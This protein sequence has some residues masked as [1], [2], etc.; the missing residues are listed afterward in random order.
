MAKSSFALTGDEELARQLTAI[1]KTA[2]GRVLKN[3]VVSGG[4]LIVNEW[5]TTSPFKTGNYRRSQHVG[6]EGA[7]GGLEGDSTGT[8]I[9]GQEIGSDYAEVSIGTNVEYGPRIEFGYEDTDSLG[10]TYHQPAGG[11][12]R[13]AIESTRG[14][15]EREI[16]GAVRA[17]LRKAVS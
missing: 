7:A 2:R 4:L 9:G 1:G 3:A 17:Q 15:V 6:G 12:L 10:R 5:K 11:Q 8:D 16:A 14:D 13:A